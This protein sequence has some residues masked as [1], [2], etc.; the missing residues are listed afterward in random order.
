M[1]RRSAVQHDRQRLSRSEPFEVF[2]RPQRSL[3]A[4]IL[5]LVVRLRA[6]LS[7]GLVALLA[8]LWLVDRMAAW[9][10][11]TVVAALALAVVLWTPSRRYVGRRGLSVLTRHR[12]RAVFV[13]RR[14]MNYTGN[15]PIL[16]WSRPTP[17]GE[18][19]WLLLRAG[20]DAHDVELNLSHVAAGCFAADA[21]VTA[22]PRMSALAVVDVIR[23]DPLAGSAVDSPLGMPAPP[24]R[25]RPV[26][27][28]PSGGG[29]SA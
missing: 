18:R 27:A 9:V 4:R 7:V 14:V 20:I 8:W 11:G 24:R 6:E 26:P 28:L 21:R 25:L 29:Q 23:R 13:E 22:H 1:S 10:A 12:L 16:F 2:T 5:G 19:V 15:L 3:P 17:V